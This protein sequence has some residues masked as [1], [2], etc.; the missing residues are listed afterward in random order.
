MDW[1]AIGTI[2]AALI[3]GVVGI[4]VAVIR[5]AEGTRDRLDAVRLQI[6]EQIADLR[7]DL[8]TTRAGLAAAQADVSTLQRRVAELPA[9][10]VG[11]VECRERHE[12]LIREMDDLRAEA[13]SRE[14]RPR[15][16]PAGG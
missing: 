15:L 10:P 14:A 2:L 9:A 4:I 3:A 11:E 8:A 12:D 6:G 1:A 7:D 5:S 13:Q 16:V